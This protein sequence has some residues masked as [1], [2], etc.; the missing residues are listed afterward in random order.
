MDDSNRH[1]RKLKSETDKM[2]AMADSLPCLNQNTD[3]ENQKG[4]LETS[5][6]MPQGTWYATIS[7]QADERGM[8]SS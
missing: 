6:M 1:L 8:L 2:I 5:H 7:Y 3:A 4:D